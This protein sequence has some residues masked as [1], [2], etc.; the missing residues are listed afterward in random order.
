MIQGLKGTEFMRALAKARDVLP[1]IMKTNVILH[2]PD[3]N[4][5]MVYG[6]I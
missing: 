6:Y 2:N 3:L 4:Y 1:P 5:V